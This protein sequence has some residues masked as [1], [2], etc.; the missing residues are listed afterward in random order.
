MAELAEEL[1]RANKELEAF[2]Y[3]VSHDLRAPLRHIVGFSDLLLESA[4]SEDTT[5]RQ[6]FLTNIK[7]SARLAGK[8]VDDLL[9]F[10]QMGRAALRPVE[11]D[12]SKLVASCID[13]LASISAGRN[14]EWDIAPLPR[15]TADPTFLHLAVQ[16]LLS[17]AVKFTGQR[18]PAADPDLVR[19]D[20]IRNGVP[21][22]RQ[23]RRLQHGLR[24]QAVRRV[25]APA[26]DGRLPGH[27]HRPGQRAP[28]RRAPWRTC[29]GRLRAGPGRHLLIQHSA[30]TRTLIALPS[31]TMLKPILLVE[32][33][34][35]DL[36]LTLVALARSQLANEVVVVRDGAEALDYLLRRGEF[37][38][39]A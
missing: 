30:Q 12:M 14:I 18:D 22:R 17:N 31:Q 3:S 26:P 28:H 23:R 37:A 11:V 35:H 8:L 16:N 2:S 39:R 19:T 15:I 25:P 6:R 34:P 9:S 7:E 33:N 10:S 27:R 1:G 20:R 21:H 32:D 5:M 24:A 36:E 4:G 29:L 13:K 38:E